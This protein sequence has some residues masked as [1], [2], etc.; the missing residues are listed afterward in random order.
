M[1]SPLIPA[2][3]WPG[4]EQMNVIPSAGIVT[5]PV[6]DS[7]ASAPMTVPSANVRSWYVP[8]SLTKVT[9]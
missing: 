2:S 6:A 8:P 1:T 7:W 9:V 3:A 5:S 4:T